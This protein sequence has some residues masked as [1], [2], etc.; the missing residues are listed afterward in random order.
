VGDTNQNL[1]PETIE[2]VRQAGRDASVPIVGSECLALLE[3]LK[4]DGDSRIRLRDEALAVLTK[5]AARGVEANGQTGLVIGY[6]QSGKTMSFTTVAALARDNAYQMVI[7]ITGVSVPLFEQSKRRLQNDLRLMTRQDRRWQ[8]FSNPSTRGSDQRT[9]ADT[10]AEWRDATVPESERKTILITVMKNHKHLDNLGQVLSG[11]D[12]RGV[13]T[14]VVDDEADQAGLN[15]LVSQGAESPTYRMLLAIRN[16]LPQHGF[17]QYTATPQAPLLINLIDVLSPNF[18]E[19]LT[20]GPEYVGGRELFL[21]HPNLIRTIPASQIPTQD[22]QIVEPPDTLLE[23]MR[24]FFLGVAAGLALSGEIGNRSMMVHPS[25]LRTGHGQ[26]FHWVT[27]VRENWNRLLELDSGNS[28]RVELLEDFRT[29]FVDLNSTVVNLPSFDT[30]VGR[31]HHA[32]RRTRVEEVNSRRGRTPQIDWTAS[33]P[34]ILV[35]GQAMD[36]GFTVEGLTVTYMPRSLGVGNADTIQQRA[37]FFGY[38]RSYLQFCRVFLENGVRDAY[39]HY[40]EH[41]EDVRNRLSDHAQTGRPLREWKR[42]FFLNRAL[43]PTRNNVLQLDY[44]Q[45]AFS[46]D[47]FTP[48]S[49]HD[50]DEATQSNRNVVAQFIGRISLEDDEGHARR[51]EMQKHKVATGVPL[52]EAYEQLLTQMRITHAR[53]SQRFTGALLQIAA[54]IDDNPDA[55]CTVFVMS[56]GTAR[57]RSVDASNE[58]PTLFQGSNPGIE[59]GNPITTYPGDSEIRSSSG[60]TIQIHKLNISNPNHELVASDVPAVAIWVPSPMAADWVSQ[61]QGGS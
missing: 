4:L 33:Y 61:H 19:L 32:I 45:D 41:E 14:L 37:R 50:S 2:V 8:H 7:V 42:A 38:K 59:N 15:T 13:A 43:R 17:L 54:Y 34:F 31:L 36:R 11:L 39:R 48:K 60:L 21:D 49:P 9:M 47:W 44:M 20:P 56:G 46:D 16:W 52:R 51:T 25:Q 3:H 53:D 40:V 18:A 30:L 10:L 27:Q 6:V 29:A 5:C 23:A 28:D 22:N 58:I 24:T 26:Y 1:S 35:G 55:T 12:L 57:T